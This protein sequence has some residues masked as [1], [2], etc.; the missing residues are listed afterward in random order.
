MFLLFFIIIGAKIIII[1]WMRYLLG[2]NI[3][4]FPQ[5]IASSYSLLSV[6]AGFSVAAR[7]LARVTVMAVMSRAARMQAATT[8]QWMGMW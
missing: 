2:G 4:S 8:Y 7:R 5:R 1:F 3:L 6:F